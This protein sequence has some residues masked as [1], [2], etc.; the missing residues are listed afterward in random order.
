MNDVQ[1]FVNG[2]LRNHSMHKRYIAV[3]TALSM[4]VSIV[5]TSI[6]VMPADSKAG[7]LICEKTEHIHDESCKKLVCGLDEVIYDEVTTEAVSQ[8][9]GQFVQLAQLEGETVGDAKTEASVE[10]TESSEVVEGT[11]SIIECR[12]NFG[13]Y[14]RRYSSSGYREC[15]TYSYR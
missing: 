12:R 6:L 7:S 1:K 10:V 4:V 8:A 11:E 14:K 9:M 3:L 13:R 15:T 2:I 5:V